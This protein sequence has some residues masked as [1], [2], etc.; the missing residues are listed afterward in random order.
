M[1]YKLLKYKYFYVLK[2]KNYLY[3]KNHYYYYNLGIII[4][5]VN[6]FINNSISII[7]FTIIK[8]TAI[9]L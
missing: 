2:F 9:E 5:I 3:H 1:K 4:L 6:S 8:F 7:Y